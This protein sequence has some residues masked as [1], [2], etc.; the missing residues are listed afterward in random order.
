M[1]INKDNSY[2]SLKEAAEITGY[3]P[4]YIGQLIRSGKL[5]GKQVFQ[6][7]VWVT[8]EDALEKYLKGTKK[9]TN[10][11]GK[12]P[13]FQDFFTVERLSIIYSAFLWFAITL[14]TLFVLFL[15]YIFA[16]SIDHKVEQRHLERLN[17]RE[18]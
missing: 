1:R 11:D 10:G 6:Q 7:V 17:A 4:D 18:L 8:T 15:G 13:S 14:F 5:E 9:G 12:M 3:S 2:I 16:V